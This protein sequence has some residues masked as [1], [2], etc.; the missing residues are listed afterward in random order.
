MVRLSALHTA[1]L[2]PQE[3]F[4][5]H[6]SVRGWVS[7]K[8]IVR[9]KD[10]MNEKLNDT[11]GNRTRDLSTWGAVWHE[12]GGKKSEEW[13]Y[14]ICTFKTG[15]IFLP[16]SVI[17]EMS[18]LTKELV[19]EMLGFLWRRQAHQIAVY[20]SLNLPEIY[21]F[22]L[23]VY[24]IIQ[25]NLNSNSVAVAKSSTEKCRNDQLLYIVAL[26]EYIQGYS[27]WLSGF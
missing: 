25:W 11:T 10:Y 19:F 15:T 5:V 18:W 24:N 8:A 20:L 17:K 23:K 9:Q 16:F 14:W 1:R 6:I 4:L 22:Y 2:H 13:I 12:Q 26:D 27:K 7:S 3:I 21:A